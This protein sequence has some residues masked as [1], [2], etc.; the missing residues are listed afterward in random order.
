MTTKCIDTF[1]YL[2]VAFD[3]VLIQNIC[4]FHLLKY[5]IICVSVHPV[6]TFY[7]LKH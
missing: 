4:L 7:A 2:I 3:S 5:V 1:F 6:L